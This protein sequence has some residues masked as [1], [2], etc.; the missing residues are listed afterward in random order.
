MIIRHRLFSVLLKDL[1]SADLFDE[2]TELNY[3]KQMQN[4]DSYYVPKHQKE[5]ENLVNEYY[6]VKPSAGLRTDDFIIRKSDDLTDQNFE[7]LEFVDDDIEPSP[8]QERA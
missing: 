5:R 7:K 6:G 4:A 1:I 3:Y 2:P 8:Q